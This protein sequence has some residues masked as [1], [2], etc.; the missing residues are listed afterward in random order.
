MAAATMSDLKALA[1]IITENVDA[2]E[3]LSQQTGINHPSIND[4]YDPES[5]AEQFT[6]RQEVLSSAM[7][8]T[9][10][11]SQLV[12]TLKLPGLSLLDRANAFHIPS[13]LRIASEACVVEILREAGPKGMHAKDIALKSNTDPIIMSR[14]LRLLATHYVFR[15]LE[16]NVFANNRISSMM[17]TDKSSEDV[18]AISRKTL[19]NSANMGYGVSNVQGEKYLNTSGVPALVEQ[20]TDEVFKSSAFLPSVVL[21]N[22]FSK[23]SF[24]KALQF[25]GTMWE[26][27]EKN[28]GY[29]QRIQ[30]AMVAWTKL[31][32]QQKLFKG[33]DWSKLPRDSLVVDLGG[34]N[35]SE[36]FEI[37]KK[38]PHLKI[39][40]QDREQ[41]IQQVTVPTWEGNSEQAAM[42]KSGQVK[43]EAQD[44]FESQPSHIAQKVSMFFLRFITHDWKF[45]QCV[46]IL[47]QLHAA[48]SPQTKVMLVDQLV[49]YACPTPASLGR[50]I[51]KGAST[52][53]P[54]LLT[55]FGEANSDVYTTDYTMAVLL[56]A[57][58]RTLGEF[59]E[60]LAA[61]G[62]KIEI[63]YQTVGSCLSQIVCSKA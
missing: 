1:A 41:T 51:I 44:F 38:A 47:T 46:K 3:R 8:A 4:L 10:A 31:Q 35:G 55:N 7:L 6:I 34:G 33:F 21:S 2:I 43:L 9:S 58:E 37:A 17:D 20:C 29:L 32:P 54:P 49:P 63:V 48:A 50:G 40:V 59:E 39:I 5:K 22:D 26:F 25:N 60:M 12:A 36:A 18:L 23:T 42:L 52:A 19:E 53:P 45:D 14:T 27:F 11:A 61:A 56:N 24:Q 15:E 57:Q 13:A 62:W 28:P 16:P 30:M